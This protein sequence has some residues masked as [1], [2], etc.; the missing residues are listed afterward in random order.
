MLLRCFSVLELHPLSTYV[1]LHR[2]LLIS[3]LSWTVVCVV[4]LVSFWQVLQDKILLEE[5]TFITFCSSFSAFWFANNLCS[6]SGKEFWIKDFITI[7]G[8][9]KIW[10]N[11]WHWWI[12]YTSLQCSFNSS[13]GVQFTMYFLLNF[14]DLQYKKIK[15]ISILSKSHCRKQGA[16]LWYAKLALQ[17]SMLLFYLEGLRTDSVI[18]LY[19]ICN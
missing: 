8:N 3:T 11:S 14:D 1:I 18:Q 5:D 15:C 17:G 9:H 10:K 12:F 19:L 6:R 13:Y 4:F 7:L 2:W 16:Q